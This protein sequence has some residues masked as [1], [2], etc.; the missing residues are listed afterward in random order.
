MPTSHRHADVLAI[1]WK[2]KKKDTDQEGPVSR[3]EG[4]PNDF[5][6]GLITPSKQLLTLKMVGRRIQ[7]L[8]TPL[9]Q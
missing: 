3:H 1:C 2:T 4:V 7:G 6:D 9:K 5:Q 8:R